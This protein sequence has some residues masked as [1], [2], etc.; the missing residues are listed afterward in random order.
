MRR[1]WRATRVLGRLPAVIAACAALAACG[2]GG[3]SK[4]GNLPPPSPPT[5]AYHGKKTQAP[6]N[7]TNA[8]P[9]G[10]GV[11]LSANNMQSLDANIGQP[12]PPGNYDKTVAGPYGGTVHVYGTIK[13]DDTGVLVERYNSYEEQDSGVIV[14]MN[15]PV[16]LQYNPLQGGEDVNVTATFGDVEV[17][18][19]GDDLVLSGDI[20]K[21]LTSTPSEVTGKQQADLLLTDKKTNGQTWLH[22]LTVNYDSDPDDPLDVSRTLS[23]RYYLS[24]AGYMDV[25]TKNKLLYGVGADSPDTPYPH[26]GGPLEVDGTGAHVLLKPMNYSYASLGLDTNGD[27]RVNHGNLYDWGTAAFYRDT[28]L[29]SRPV[30]DARDYQLVPEGAPVT[31][32]GRM[33]RSEGNGFLAYRWSLVYAPPGS[34]VVLDHPDEGTLTFS[35][36]VDGHYLV[37]LAVTDA[38]G[39]TAHS[40]VKFDY[41]SGNTSTTAYVGAADAGPDETAQAGSLVQLD[42]ALSVPYQSIRNY[43]WALNKPPGSQA[44][45]VGADT[46]NPSFTPDVPGIYQVTLSTSEAQWGSYDSKLVSVGGSPVHFERVRFGEDPPLNVFYQASAMGDLNGDGIPDIVIADSD[47]AKV[48]YAEGNGRFGAPEAL[49]DF[50]AFEATIGDL[51][52]DGRNDLVLSNAQASSAS[53]APGNVLVFLQQAGGTL[54][55]GQSWQASG[56]TNGNTYYQGPPEITRLF[57]QSWNSLWMPESPPQ[58]HVF[59]LDGD[60]NADPQS[61]FSYAGSY[62]TNNIDYVLADVNGDGVKDLVFEATPNGAIDNRLVVSPGATNGTFLAPVAYTAMYGGLAAADINGDGRQDIILMHTYSVPATL[63]IRYGEG[64]G[65]LSAPVT[66]PVAAQADQS[67]GPWPAKP[68]GAD[69]KA[70]LFTYS[71]TPGNADYLSWYGINADGSL[72]SQWLYPLNVGY[73]PDALLYSGDLDGDG[74][75]DLILQNEFTGRI[76]LFF[77][78]PWPASAA[79]GS[80]AD[81][82]F[83]S[84]RHDHRREAGALLSAAGHVLGGGGE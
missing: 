67:G 77:A 24:N 41:P 54:G 15:G 60:G 47:G 48:Y 35:P 63:G 59:D 66:Y 79:S 37:A 70:L 56:T 49:T 83:H 53:G 39:D 84:G 52:N 28:G 16:T 6:A 38:Q 18:G 65:S 7:T 19:G 5:Y 27:G 57:G 82:T 46:P 74:L 11:V 40:Y 31:L 78:T 43:S 8:E 20:D 76:S 12:P 30:A 21:T 2:G 81:E 73:L 13:A 23:G 36:D 69:K 34:Q 55:H 17:S 32:D 26:T 45:L 25:S 62:T 1:L 80:A 42:G 61:D 51:N 22:P 64:D 10:V 75:T 9:F 29:S 58:Y 4:S 50:S 3:G 68:P 14:T 72:G 71:G 33:S 44:T